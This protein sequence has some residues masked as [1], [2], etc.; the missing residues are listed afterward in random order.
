VFPAL[1]AH[2]PGVVPSVTALL[3]HLPGVITEINTVG[4]FDIRADHLVH[5]MFLQQ[6]CGPTDSE[7]FDGLGG[8]RGAINRCVYEFRE[9]SICIR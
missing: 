4:Q 8:E 9:G 6:G 2:L 3:A 1:L 7:P 5:D